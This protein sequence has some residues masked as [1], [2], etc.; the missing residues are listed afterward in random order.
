MKKFILFFAIVISLSATKTFAQDQRMQMQQAFKSY[1]KDSV[2]LSDVMVDSVMAVR[3][4]Y[5]PQMRTVFMD[6]SSSMQDKQTKMQSM[7]TEMEARYKAAGLTDDQVA[8][9]HKHEDEMRAQMMQR[10]NNNGG[11]G[12]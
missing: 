8:A 7:R 4:Q 6:Q 2:K 10:M 1:L 3:A 11:G 12:N 5:Q 9:I